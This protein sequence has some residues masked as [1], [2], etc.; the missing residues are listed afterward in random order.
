MATLVIFATT[1]IFVGCEKEDNKVVEQRKELLKKQKINAIGDAETIGLIHN[2]VLNYIYIKFREDN[3]IREKSYEELAELVKIY[4]FEYIQD[5]NILS[6]LNSD[7]I[8][9]FLSS[10]D[11]DEYKNE[12]TL[13]NFTAEITDEGYR[14][15]I[16]KMYHHFE[17]ESFSN[18]AELSSYL[19]DILD[20]AVNED[21]YEDL[22]VVAS[23]CRNSYIY[24]DANYQNWIDLFDENT[25]DPENPEEPSICYGWV[26]VYKLLKGDFKG[27]VSG[28]SAGLAFA[29]VGAAA[30]A[31]IGAP[32]G[33]GLAGIDIA[34]EKAAEK[35]DAKKAEK[36]SN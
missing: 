8:S 36:T 31:L 15:V 12:L 20:N 26:E 7:E 25:E 13:E 32:V 23:V 14:D 10:V 30:G 9:I 35:A 3:E 33:S 17:M 6:E 11:I 28:A 21:F 22:S 2:E 27:A 16:T 18:I 29:G 24:W 5:N 4:T 1:A 19:N 34:L